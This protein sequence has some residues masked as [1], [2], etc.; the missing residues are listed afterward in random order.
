MAK[1]TGKFPSSP[2]DPHEFAEAEIA[3]QKGFKN[4]KSAKIKFADSCQ[5]DQGKIDKF[6]ETFASKERSHYS[7]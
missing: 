5:P 6:Y 3:K 2:K 4:S 1:Y 7:A